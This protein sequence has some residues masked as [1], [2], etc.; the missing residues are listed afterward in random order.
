MSRKA[1]QVKLARVEPTLYCCSQPAPGSLAM[2]SLLQ[3]LH[4]QVSQLGNFSLT[5]LL[6]KKLAKFHINT[7]KQKFSRKT[8][9]VKLACVETALQGRGVNVVTVCVA[10]E[11]HVLSVERIS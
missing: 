2:F 10:F 1:C 5:S 4:E 8:C 6:V 3:H 7:S 11:Q 9:Q